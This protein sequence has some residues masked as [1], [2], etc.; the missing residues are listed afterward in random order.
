M[1][2]AATAVSCFSESCSFMTCSPDVLVSSR[3]CR[4]L[5]GGFAGRRGTHLLGGVGY[6]YTWP[7]HMRRCGARSRYM[8]FCRLR[9]FL[10]LLGRCLSVLFP[11]FP[12][13]TCA[14][15]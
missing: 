6:V 7:R 1:Q 13:L 3:L 14:L 15:S 12:L 11:A 10:A 8:A 9:P 4:N 2:V 5:F